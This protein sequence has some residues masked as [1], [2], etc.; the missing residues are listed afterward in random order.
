MTRTAKVV[1]TGSETERTKSEQTILDK[2]AKYNER[3]RI[4]CLVMLGTTIGLYF[5]TYGLFALI[6]LVSLFDALYFNPTFPRFVEWAV[7]DV[8]DAFTLC[9]FAVEAFLNSGM[10]SSQDHSPFFSESALKLTQIALLPRSLASH[11]H[12]I[13]RIFEHVPSLLASLLPG[14]AHI[15]EKSLIRLL[16][17]CA[18]CY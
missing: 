9:I 18:Q 15:V 11:Q 6:I 3:I 14:G 10:C 17:Q 2:T 5:A 7:V 8:A 12:F 16:C 4:T 13:A 1:Y